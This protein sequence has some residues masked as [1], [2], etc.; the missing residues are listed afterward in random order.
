MLTFPPH[1]LLAASIVVA[2]APTLVLTDNAQVSLHARGRLW[3]PVGL[4][5]GVLGHV[6]HI[7]MGLLCTFPCPVSPF[8][9]LLPS[10]F[11]C[12]HCV[13]MFSSAMQCA[14]SVHEGG[15][16][17]FVC[18]GF[19]FFLPV[20]SSHSFSCTPLPTSSHVLPCI[21]SVVVCI[22][23]FARWGACVRSVRGL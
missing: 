9:L 23:V 1:S 22:C 12:Y 14:D 4:L 13:N 19:F 10:S 16:Q 5:C 17:W 21:C 11:P 2:N 6:T 18:R 8:P 15:K 20:T 3:V 7:D